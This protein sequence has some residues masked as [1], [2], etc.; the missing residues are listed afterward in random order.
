MERLHHLLTAHD[1][2]D[3]L[4]HIV[5]E[6][7]GNKEDNELELAFRRFTD[8]HQFNFEPIFAHK[9][10]NSAGL[11]F[12]DLVARPIGRHVMKPEQQNRSFDIL[13]KKLYR[14]AGDYRGWGLKVFP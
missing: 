1:Q 14:V 2:A 12:A 11:Q 6:R 8:Q 7:R 4:T 5:L 9:Q 3:K 13:N 10:N